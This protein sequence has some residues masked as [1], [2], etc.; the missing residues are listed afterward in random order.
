VGALGIPALFG[1][2]EA[3]Y[4]FLSTSL[5]P[6][7]LNAYHAV[8]IDERRPQ[9]PATLWQ[10]PNPPVP[11]QT[12][13]Q[14]Y[15]SGVHCDVGGGYP[16]TQLSDITFGW[17]AS[18]AEALGALFDDTALAA[19]KAITAKNAIGTKHESWDAVWGIPRSRSID[20]ASNLGNSVSIRYGSDATYR[21]A[22]LAVNGGALAS[23][24]STLDVVIEDSTGS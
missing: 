5:H 21:P 18:K 8:S 10:L 23:T 9:F 13:V 20:A 12:L 11:N 24:Y 15:F 3:D 19:Y 14:A 1:G 17:M 2:V 22:N 7:V 16:E 4:Q 6:D